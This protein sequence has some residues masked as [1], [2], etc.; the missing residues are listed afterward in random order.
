MNYV[1]DL[2]PSGT[3]YIYRINWKDYSNQQHK[4]FEQKVK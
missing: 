1:R 4:V 3:V 2:L